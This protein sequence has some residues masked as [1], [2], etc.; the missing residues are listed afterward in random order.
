MTPDLANRVESAFRACA[1]LRERANGD[2]TFTIDGAMNGS[3]VASY[4]LALAYAMKDEAT[5]GYMYLFLPSNAGCAKD[6]RAEVFFDNANR[7][8]VY[9]GKGIYSEVGIQLAKACV[10]NGLENCDPEMDVITFES[11]RCKPGHPDTVASPRS[12]EL[13]VGDYCPCDTDEASTAVD[14][15]ICTRLGKGEKIN[16]EVMRMASEANLKARTGR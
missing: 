7:A 8:P 15:D 2:G 6:E 10:A 4:Q 12:A 5:K 9:E 1:D 14:A 16:P 3:A 11:M 13:C